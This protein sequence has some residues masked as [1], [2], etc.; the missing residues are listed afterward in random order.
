MCPVRETGVHVTERVWILE[1]T[2]AGAK[3]PHHVS[4]CVGDKALDEAM[5]EH[6]TDPSNK[7]RARLA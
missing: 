5:R 2:A 1:V 6:E 3:E 4:R 7:I